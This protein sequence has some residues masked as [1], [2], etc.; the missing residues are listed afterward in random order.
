MGAWWLLAIISGTGLAGRNVLLKLANNKID[1]AVAALF[2]SLAMSVISF[3]YYV[4]QRNSVKLPLIPHE[5][6]VSGLM[7]A[8]AAGVS[9]A[10]A[11]L[12]LAYSYKAGGGAALTGMLQSGVSLCVTLVIGVL[13]LSEVIRPIQ[14]VGVF[15]AIGGILLII[16]G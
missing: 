16:K 11:N 5:Q 15:A 10:I 6:D 7:L 12:L 2:M 3:V 4:Y 9:L 13:L 1:G 14:A 8:G